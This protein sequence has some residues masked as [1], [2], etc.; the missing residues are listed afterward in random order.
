VRFT[1]NGL[2]QR[3]GQDELLQRLDGI[4]NIFATPSAALCQFEN[5]SNCLMQA[6]TSIKKELTDML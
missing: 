1:L 6:L 3:G 2:F 4:T 5:I